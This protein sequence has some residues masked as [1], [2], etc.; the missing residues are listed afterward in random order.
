[1][2]IITYI[3]YQNEGLVNSKANFWLINNYNKIKHEK[4][5]IAELKK[6]KDIF[7]IKRQS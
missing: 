6:N 7:C 1:M 5:S 2:P 3:F 4:H